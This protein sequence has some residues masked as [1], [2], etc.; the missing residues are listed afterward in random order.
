M[1]KNKNQ[2]TSFPPILDKNLVKRYIQKVYYEYSI[3]DPLEEKS[4]H[5]TPTNKNKTAH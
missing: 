4:K 3:E 1:K 5:Y 2:S